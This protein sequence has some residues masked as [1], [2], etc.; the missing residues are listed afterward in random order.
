M[1]TYLLR[2]V[3]DI[4]KESE[5]DLS[6]KLAQTVRNTGNY[7][8]E[9]AVSRQLDDY[10]AVVG[11]DQVPHGAEQLILSMSNF[12]SPSTDMGNFS[13]ELEKKNIK[14][15]VMIGAGA[16]AHSYDDPTTL[17]EG[18]QRFL[19]LLSDKSETIGVRGF[20]TKEVLE[21]Y[22]VTNGE[23]IGCPSIFYNL[24]RDF[25]ISK[26][27][28]SDTPKFAFHMT[29]TGHYRDNIS[30][31]MSTGIAH[32]SAYIA[33]SERDLISVVEQPEVSD[34][35]IEFMFKYYNDGTF[36]P[37]QIRDW[38]AENCKWFFDL[39][40]WFGYMSTMDFSL[41]ARFHGNMAALQVNVPALN[42]VFDTRTREMCEFLN[43]PIMFLK[44]F[45]GKESIEELYD[46]AD[47]TLFNK[48][49]S[50]KYDNYAA[51]LSRN[52]VP[53]KLTNV[54]PVESDRIAPVNASGIM[55]LLRELQGKNLDDKLVLDTI[56][57]RFEA[58]RSYDIRKQ[59]EAGKFDAASFN[60]ASV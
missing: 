31:L 12:L 6:G 32:G 46:R 50:D 41:G 10:E 5:L 21:K 43:L 57:A 25:A 40:S 26:Q 42:L 36:S 17:T 58:D 23:V 9:H 56:M 39:E 15:I 1:T 37:R 59:A 11:L 30:H 4:G 18:T 54:E 14:Q 52:K 3:Q 51:F 35:D 13:R 20:Y 27:A 19:S 53:N 48:T 45:T 7:F 44:D 38:F 2:T 49:Y 28:L 24:D 34:E 8:F 22:G 55:R 60:Q 29:P 47:Y 16:Q 33:Q